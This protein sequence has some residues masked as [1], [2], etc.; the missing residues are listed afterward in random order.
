MTECIYLKILERKCRC[1]SV[2]HCEYFNKKVVPSKDCK[3]CKIP[4]LEELIE[5]PMID[6]L[7]VLNDSLIQSN[8]PEYYDVAEGSKGIITVGGGVS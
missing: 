3:T 2:Q 5:E 1:K 4:Q 7:K 8:L 6:Y